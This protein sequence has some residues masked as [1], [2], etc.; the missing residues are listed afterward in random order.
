MRQ[1]SSDGFTTLLGALIGEICLLEK[2]VNTQS[3]KHKICFVTHVRSQHMNLYSEL[4]R[5]YCPVL[6]QRHRDL[7]AMNEGMTGDP[8]ILIAKSF[9]ISLRR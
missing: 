3:P 4:C 2:G 6:R 5:D 8:S 1:P 9:L 7:R